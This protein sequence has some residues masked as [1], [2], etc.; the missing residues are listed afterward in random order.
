M[1]L[2]KLGSNKCTCTLFMNMLVVFKVNLV[3]PRITVQSIHILHNL[4]VNGYPCLKL[5]PYN[6]LIKLTK[7]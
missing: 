7:A 2:H 6:Q 3:I 4:N 5:N 1:P